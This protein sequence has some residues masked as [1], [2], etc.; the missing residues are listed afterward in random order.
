VT[1]VCP[2]PVKTAFFD[3]AEETGYTLSVKKFF[4]AKPEKVVAYALECAKQRK[5]LSIYSA[6]MKGLHFIGKIFPHRIILEIY[7]QMV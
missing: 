7:N 1:A 2:G 5:Q 6:A 3:V 4:M